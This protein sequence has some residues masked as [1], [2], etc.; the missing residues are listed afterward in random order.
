MQGG[1]CATYVLGNWLFV[2]SYLQLAYRL[3]LVVAYKDPTLF[4]RKITIMTLVVSL[5][6]VLAAVFFVWANFNF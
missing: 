2:S 4:E 5:L 6:I 3:E 1:L